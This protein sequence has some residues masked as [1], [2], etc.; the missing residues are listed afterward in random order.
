MVCQ[1]VPASQDVKCLQC[2]W[3][4]MLIVAALSVGF[5]QLIM[6]ILLWSHLQ[7]LL[8]CAY[9]QGWIFLWRLW[10]QTC[11]QLV[12]RPAAGKPT[13]AHQPCR[14]FGN[15]ASGLY[16]HTSV[17]QLPCCVG[18]GSGWLWSLHAVLC[19]FRFLCLFVMVRQAG[20]SVG[21]LAAYC[22]VGLLLQGVIGFCYNVRTAVI[23]MMATDRGSR[24]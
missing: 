17:L 22:V 4:G 19:R 8:A 18:F 7:R 2:V 16:I 13:S 24:Y 10:F 3:G 23:A 1:C 12:V 14:P 11:V 21:W 5:V 20:G 15:Q 6:L 9:P